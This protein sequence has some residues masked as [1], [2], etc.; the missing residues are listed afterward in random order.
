MDIKKLKQIKDK[1]KDPKLVK[2]LEEKIKTLEGNKTV[3]K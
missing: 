3:L 1:A 2:H